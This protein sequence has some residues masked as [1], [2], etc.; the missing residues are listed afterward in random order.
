MQTLYDVRRFTQDMGLPVSETPTLLPRELL[1]LRLVYMLEEL[2]EFGQAHRAGDLPAAADALV[3]L[4]YFALGTAVQM[5]LPWP[6]LWD[7]VHRAN[8]NKRIG[9][10]KY[11]NRAG[12]VKPD[13]WVSPHDEIVRILQDR[14]ES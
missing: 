2:S 8:L 10:D 4:V 7:V 12:V 1:P 3:D 14:R 13:G 9:Y 5:G 6:E 11:G